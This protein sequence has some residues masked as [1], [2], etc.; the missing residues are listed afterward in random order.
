MLINGVELSALGVQLHNRIITSNSIETTHDW[1]DGDVQPTFVRQQDKFKNIKLQ[2]LITEKNEEDAFVIMSN[3]TML[4]K[5]A[6][7]KFDDMTLQFD[8]A[9]V[10][11]TTQERLRNGSFIFTVNLESDYAKGAGEVY[12]TDT[13][14]TDAFNLTVMYYKDTNTLISSDTVTI[15]SIDF[16]NNDKVTFETL[17]IDIN[18]YQPEYYNKG[19]L[20]NFSSG[21]ISYEA[22]RN[23]Q[24]LFI[25]YTPTV[26]SITVEY[27]LNDG[28]VYNLIDTVVVS[29]TKEKVDNSTVIGQLIDLNLN[30][31]NGYAAT[32]NFNDRLTFENLMAFNGTLSIYFDIIPDERTKEV[33][34]H[35]LAERN[36]EMT[37]EYEQTLVVSEGRV[38][39]GTKIGDL[40]N[41]NGY[42]P[43]KYYKD[44]VL[45]RIDGVNLNTL[46]TFD[47]IESEYTIKY[48]L[49]ESPVYVEYYYG[50]YPSWNRHNTELYK[51]TC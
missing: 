8:V 38:V 28:L 10:G 6:S 48:E 36:G 33:K 51:F 17:G 42:K 19:K 12:T 11:Q 45:D 23:L 31:P 22:L 29:F 25:N 46:I 5:K 34:I 50:E 4:L 26:Y 2:F 39:D 14:A 30:R 1:L 27:Y 3:L 37:S 43:D 20:T 47:T 40:F 24:V 13:A 32:T 16:T 44:G 35:Y 9:L 21:E 18:K 7:I 41:V 49:I 15:R